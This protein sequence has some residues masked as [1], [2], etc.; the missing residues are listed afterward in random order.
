MYRG[1]WQATVHGFNK[2]LDNV[3]HTHTS[4]VYHDFLEQF[5]AHNMTQ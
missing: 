4:L 1:A 2:E 3:K 5:V